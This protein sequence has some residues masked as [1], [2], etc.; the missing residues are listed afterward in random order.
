M[1]RAVHRSGV[2]AALKIIHADAPSEQLDP[3]AGL[4]AE[5]RAVAAL[6][7]PNIV[8]VYDAGVL[9]PEHEGLT[10]GKLVAGSP[11]LAMELADGSVYDLLEDMDWTVLLQLLLQTLDGLAHAHARGVIHR[12]LKPA[13]VL[14]SK[15]DG[16]LRILVADFGLAWAWRGTSEPLDGGTA[17]YSSPEQLVGQ[18]T[19][20][21][22]WTD[23]YA[24]GCT[25]Y[26]LITGRRPYKGETHEELQRAHLFGDL[27]TMA[28]R[29][30]VPPGLAPWVEGL[31]AKDPRHRYQR[32]ADAAWSLLQLPPPVPGEVDEEDDDETAATVL[33]SARFPTRTLPVIAWAQDTPPRPTATTPPTPPG[34]AEPARVRPPVP[35]RWHGPASVDRRMRGRGLGLFGMAA[36]PIVARE[37]ERDALWEALATGDRLHV[38]VMSGEAGVGKSRLGAWL[39]ERAHEVGAAAVFR[40]VFHVEP[41]AS[42]GLAA[43]M[44]EHLRT[45]GMSGPDLLKHLETV[46]LS[47]DSLDHGVTSPTIARLLRPVDQDLETPA[48]T[49]AERVRTCWR[50]MQRRAEG[51]RLVVWLDDAENHA[52]ARALVQHLGEHAADVSGLL[53]LTVTDAADIAEMVSDVEGQLEVTH[54]PL[55]RLDEAES[56]DMVKRMLPIPDALAERIGQASAGLPRAAVGLVA[57]LVQQGQLRGDSDGVEVDPTVPL[58]ESLASLYEGALKRIDALGDDARQALEVAAVLG[59]SVALPEWREACELVAVPLDPALLARLSMRGVMVPARG[60]G[61]MTFGSPLLRDALLDVIG[62]E[63]RG[64][65]LHRVCGEIL[66]TRGDVRAA[67]CGHHLEAGGLYDRAASAYLRAM[68][69]LAAWD[70]ERA[71]EIGTRWYATLAR[72]AERGDP[73]FTEG[74]QVVVELVGAQGGDA[75]QSATEE[76]LQRGRGDAQAETRALIELAQADLRALELDRALARAELAWHRSQDTELRP[77]AAAI[78]AEVRR[79]RG[80][81]EQAEHM[82]RDAL[83]TD[84][85]AA[86]L[87]LALAR[88]LSDDDRANEALTLLDDWIDRITRAKA[89]MIRARVQRARGSAFLALGKTKQATSALTSAIELRDRA[90]F[91]WPDLDLDLAAALAE[92]GEREEGRRLLDQLLERLDET[93]DIRFR[94]DALSLLATMDAVDGDWEAVEQRID[95]LEDLPRKGRRAGTPERLISLAFRAEKA[96]E[97]ALGRRAR[98]L[99]S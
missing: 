36:A 27:P 13:N 3:V 42:S 73:R 48:L 15:A 32:A 2:P 23:L 44:E 78:R 20:Q 68:R 56:A 7:H 53:L 25:A 66:E 90:G 26:R 40:T 30:A 74:M 49:V 43:M 47:R 69:W 71:L 58:P 64:Q 65:G 55:R 35:N 63:G 85:D 11:W 72:V 54:M 59:R 8:E 91:D 87:M 76:L 51:R 86:P 62:Q 93:R 37:G 38:V 89:P 84:A 24:L 4:Q 61:R 81:L 77:E 31:M 94:T 16:Q 45:H 57:D 1:W 34:D 52:D 21:G 83:A 99:A 29:F 6:E 33:S 14:Y 50:L 28:S 17:A 95:A 18:L 82:L 70:R 60:G 39:C 46:Q 98:E 97:V 79:H 12:D 19:E 96:G 5:I 92:D 67:S 10:G 80:D 88:V 22:P 41:S 75:H 9:G